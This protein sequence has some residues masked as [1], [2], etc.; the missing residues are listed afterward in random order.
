MRAVEHNGSEAAVDTRF[1]GCEIRTVVEVQ[2]NR[3]V[4]DFESRFDEVDEVLMVRVLSC[5]GGALKD[6]GRFEFGSGTRDALNDFHVVD[7]ERADSEAAFVSFLEHS[8]GR[9]QWHLALPPKNYHTI[10]GALTPP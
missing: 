8:F 1:A 6:D 4:A 5:A 10:R 3:N 2:S 7:V 9:N